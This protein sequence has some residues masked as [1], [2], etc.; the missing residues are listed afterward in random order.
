MEQICDVIAQYHELLGEEMFRDL[1][2]AEQFQ[3]NMRR[4]HLTQSGRLIAP[5]LRPQFISPA[6]LHS[7][8][9]SSERLAA[10]LHRAQAMVI[11]SPTLL[12]RLRLL[13]A[14][15]MLATVPVRNA[16]L[17]TACRFDARIS[18]GSLCICGFNACK[19]E[20]FAHSELLADL[21]LKLPIMKALGQGRYRF[22]KLANS[23]GLVSALLLTW[24]EF[25]GGDRY[26]NV[27]ILEG[28]R[29]G[30]DGFSEGQL[31]AGL[32][33]EHGCSAQV[34]KAEN[35]Q[36]DAG[37]LRSHAFEIDVVFRRLRTS[38][39]LARFDLSHPLLRA[40]REGSVC[41]VNNFQSE[42][43]GRRAFFELLTDATFKDLLPA[44]DRELL[45]AIV[46][47]TR[48]VSERKTIYR[49][50]TVDLVPFILQNRERLTLRPNDD[51]EGGR[52]F[53]GA[54]TSPTDWERALR[55]AFQSPYVVQERTCFDRQ[56]V[57][58]FLHGDLTMKD[59]DIVVRPQLSNGKLNGAS[60][61]IE[62][63]ALNSSTCSAAAPVFVLERN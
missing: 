4:G 42:V 35:F 50:N 3:E 17:S 28:E 54:D 45:K 33:M 19:P 62:T 16:P 36:Y 43:V 56:C 29:E 26:P 41:V 44:A 32:L 20:G 14:E 46:P 48:T 9:Q 13:P 11:G 51:T 18:N 52:V 37:R 39:L 10:I 22:G 58:F 23:R 25:G 38:D 47:W 24:K 31:L 7:L 63:S 40:Y 5:V 8:T 57:P 55:T 27:A 12:N 6:Q 1:S 34:V 21:F 2:W 30:N 53:E 59:A 61:E 49:K 60:A 15:K